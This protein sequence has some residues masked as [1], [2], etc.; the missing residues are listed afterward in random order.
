MDP[1]SEVLLD[2][3]FSCIYKDHHV[4][5][6]VGTETVPAGADAK[7]GV[8]S[9]DVIIGD[10]SDVYVRLY[11]PA[12]TRA[13]DEGPKLRV[14]VFFHG[15]GFITMSAAEPLYHSYINSL[16]AAAGVLVVSVNYR[17]A[18]EH[19][20]P[21]GYEDSFRALKWA[22]AGEDP[23]LSQ[24]GDLRRV[25]LAGDSAGGNI[26]HNVAMMAVADEG[27]GVAARIEGAVLLH[28]AFGG[29]ERVAGESVET[30]WMMDTL[31]SVICPEAT[32]GVDDSRVNPLSATAP[33]LRELPFQRLLVVEADGDFFWGRGKA[34]YEGVL[35]SGWGGTVDWFETVGKHTF[36][37][38]DPSCPEAV[39]LMD[40][41]TA[42][43]AGN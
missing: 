29:K 11:L 28:A 36:F 37:L 41:L 2:L 33:S 31:W 6:I 34:Y 14:L 32:D 15:G 27:S 43:F 5:R 40:R 3:E 21:I 17:L 35:A 16:A 26:V 9:K 1:S 42:F 7:T 30:A 10:D 12:G 18:P 19:P 8:V 24:H 23:W 39:A 25:F 38:F 22:L 13:N 4:D 20:F